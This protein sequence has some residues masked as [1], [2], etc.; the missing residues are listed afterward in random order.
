MGLESFE[1]ID[2]NSKVV[3]NFFHEVFEKL[4]DQANLTSENFDNRLESVLHEVDTSYARYF[5]QDA[6]AQFTWVNLGEIVKQTAVVLKKGLEND[7][8]KT[9][10]TESAFG[11]PKSELGNFAIDKINLRG[12]ID[13]I[14]QF[15]MIVLVLLII[16]LVNINLILPRP[17]MEQ[18]YSFSL[19]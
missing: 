3:G 19:I 10:A 18:V 5:T 9:L 13:R 4:L 6:T 15:L 8:M 14:D 11:F 7:Q 2:L 17:M 1:N 12:R 16:N